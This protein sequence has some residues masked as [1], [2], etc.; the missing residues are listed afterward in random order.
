LRKASETRVHTAL[1]VTFAADGI[2]G[3]LGARVSAAQK[4]QKDRADRPYSSF[5][6]P[7]LSFTPVCDG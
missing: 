5:F 3:R 6:H 2:Q 4:R 1:N 7:F